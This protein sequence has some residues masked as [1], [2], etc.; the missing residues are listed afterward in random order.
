VFARVSLSFE[1]V[2]F[3]SW[4]DTRQGDAPLANFNETQYPIVVTNAGAI[5]ER[6]AVIFTSG[7]TVRVVGER[8]GQVIA[9]ADISSNIAPINP[10]SGV[11]YFTLP[12]LGWGSGWV[13]GNALRFNTVAAAQ[14]AW[15][16]H[17]T[18]PGQRTVV[19]DRFSLVWTGDVDRP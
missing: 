4:S 19:N 17:V 14:P 6:W 13:N 18:L 11:P 9:S 5:T 1:Q 16:A 15:V 2:N 10:A 7:T 12:A 8:T 3:S